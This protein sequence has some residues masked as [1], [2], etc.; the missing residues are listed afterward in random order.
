VFPYLPEQVTLLNW[1]VIGIPAFVIALSHESSVARPRPSFLSEVG[2]FALRTGLVFS[3]AALAVLLLSAR[4]WGMAPPGQRTVLLSTLVLLGVT[5]LFRVLA[6]VERG[7]RWKDARIRIVALLAVP[8]YL[9]V[10]YFPLTARF[11]QLEPLRPTEWLG[12]LSVVLAGYGLCLL[13]DFFF[14]P[15]SQLGRPPGAGRARVGRRA[16]QWG[17]SVSSSV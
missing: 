2:S 6:D 9:A 14:H 1:L 7:R 10:M 3:L 11:F 8:V 16:V 13:C 12:V 5:A 17:N 4:V 15:S